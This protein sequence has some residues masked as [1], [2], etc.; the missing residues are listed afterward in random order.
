[1]ERYKRQLELIGEDG[2]TRLEEATV[3]VVGA[4]GLGNICAKFLASSG[5]GY[6]EIWDFDKVEKSNL[7]RQI[8]FNDESVGKPKA[9][10]LA[11]TI[12][13]INPNITCDGIYERFDY[14]YTLEDVNVVVDCSDNMETAYYLEQE[15]LEEGIPLVFGATSRWFGCCKVIKDKP[16]L[17]KNYTTKNSNINNGVFSPIGGLVGSFQA[18]MALKLILDEKV[19]EDTYHFDILNDRFISYNN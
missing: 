14:P 6:I 13:K 11:N 18:S 17:K 4:G 2:Q 3:L 19:S 15:A 8:L 16:Y 7:N 12:R 10:A 5:V 9:V 1:M